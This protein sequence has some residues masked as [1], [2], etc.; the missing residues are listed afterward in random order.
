MLYVLFVVDVVPW[1]PLLLRSCLDPNGMGRWRN[2]EYYYY[3]SNNL[4]HFLKIDSPRWLT[5]ISAVEF[6]LAKALT[7]AIWLDAFLSF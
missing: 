6:L 5:T 4:G 3:Y 2:L 7:F 1:D